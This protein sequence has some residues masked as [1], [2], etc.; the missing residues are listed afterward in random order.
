MIRVGGD[1]DKDAHVRASV[2]GKTL[3][4]P[5]SRI[6]G[7]LDGSPHRFQEQTLLGIDHFGFRGGNS[8]KMGIKLVMV[9][10]EAAP[11]AVDFSVRSGGRIRMI[12]LLKVPPISRYH[13]DQI[14]SVLQIVPIFVQIRAVGIIPMDTDDRDLLRVIVFLCG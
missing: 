2:F 11:F 3:L 6:A 13:I 4:Q 12:E 10:Q 1:A 14:S 8:E 7:I 9:V 5:L